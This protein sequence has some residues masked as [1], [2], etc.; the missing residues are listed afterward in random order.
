MLARHR[1]GGIVA[2]ALGGIAALSFL[3][4]PPV[5]SD[6]PKRVGLLPELIRVLD[7]TQV[8]AGF[9]PRGEDAG[10]TPGFISSSNAPA[11][12]SDGWTMRYGDS[13]PNGQGF[14]TFLDAECYNFF[15]PTRDSDSILFTVNLKI[16]RQGLPNELWGDLIVFTCTPRIGSRNGGEDM[17]PV[18][19]QAILIDDVRFGDPGSRSDAYQVNGFIRISR[20]ENDIGVGTFDWMLVTDSAGQTASDD[21]SDGNPDVDVEVVGSNVTFKLRPTVDELGGGVIE[22]FAGNVSRINVFEPA[23]TLPPARSGFAGMQ[24][25]ETGHTRPWCFRIQ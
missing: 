15:A 14:P 4:S 11:V 7:G 1:L 24:A 23:G 21:D 9:L 12:L 8:E 3:F 6:A 20:L 18:P 10:A 22:T 13:R 19:A 5:L 17:P 2:V 25:G 16:P